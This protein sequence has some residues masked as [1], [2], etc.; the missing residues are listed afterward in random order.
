METIS[1][2]GIYDLKGQ[3]YDTPFFAYND[4]FAKRRFIM[5]AEKEGSVMYRFNRDFELHNLGTFNVTTGEI[6]PEKNT[7]IQGSQ[8]TGI[9]E[10][11]DPGSQNSEK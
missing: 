1:I 3:R 2:Y 11:S 9:T 10:N 6:V 7:V 4:L 8:I 5:L